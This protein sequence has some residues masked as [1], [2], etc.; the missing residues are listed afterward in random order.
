MIFSKG[1]FS[2]V[3]TLFLAAASLIIAATA[4]DDASASANADFVI[5]GAGTAGCV[6]AA[7]LCQGLPSAKIV[8]LEQG[9]ARTDEEEIVATAIAYSPTL[10]RGFEPITKT[11]T[12]APNMALFDPATGQFGRRIEMRE[13]S[14]VGGSSNVAGQW[15]IP[16][17]GTIDDW[18][19]DGLDSETAYKYFAMAEDM[20]KPQ[21][22][23]KELFENYTQDALDAYERAGFSVLNERAPFGEGGKSAYIN[24]LVVDEAGRRRSAYTAYLKPA[25]E[26]EC[27]DRL[28]LI[29]DATVTSLAFDESNKSV[30]AVKYVST[31]S[32]NSSAPVKT[33]QVNKEVILS[34]GPYGSPRLLQLNGIGP[35]EILQARGIT[36]NVANLPV[37]QATQIRPLGVS[38]GLY[39]GRP[40]DWSNDAAL[41]ASSDSR[42]QWLAGEGGPLGVAP[43]CAIG[44]IGD[45]GYHSTQF[46][47]LS[48]KGSPIA[49]T[50]C[51]LNPES[52]GNLTVV[53]DD[54]F[55]ELEIHSNLLDGTDFDR[56]VECVGAMIDVVPNGYSEDFQMSPIGRDNMTIA[57]WVSAS[58]GTSWHCVGGCA[59]GEVVDASS[60]KVIGF[61]NLRVVDASTIPRL[62]ISAGLLSSVYMLAEFASANMV[63]EYTEE[64]K[65]SPTSSASRARF[66]N[67]F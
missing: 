38:V 53:S 49:Y 13:G 61:D 7:R 30:I 6:M 65:E 63:A 62:T 25:L 36:K 37:G 40:L 32:N 1:I 48:G 8:I 28:T 12:T 59:V 23:P 54:P 55:G 26:G 57:E 20:V 17:E 21:V 52:F 33:I 56:M 15:E 14:T 50:V 22:P 29:Q 67:L 41:F 16:L 4:Q 11:H 64:E 34:A 43:H 3:A 18:G 24:Y 47:D 66:F 45:L 35:Q 60:F 2:S 46:A 42:D 10:F 51:F 58:T 31:T 27:Q 39:T 44:K 9:P 19:I 5:I